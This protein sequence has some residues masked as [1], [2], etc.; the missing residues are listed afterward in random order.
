MLSF[1][2]L[3]GFLAAC[4]TTASYVPQL[5]KCF[6]TGTAEDLSLK[7]LLILSTGIALWVAYGV[8]QHDWV[9][10]IANAV[11]LALLLMLLGFKLHE[12]HRATQ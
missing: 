7:M 5:K 12:M 4:C 10:I 9:I 11:S 6:D 8:M 2:S 1:S 3:V